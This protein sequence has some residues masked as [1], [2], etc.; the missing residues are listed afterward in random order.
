MLVPDIPGIECPGMLWP[1]IGMDELVAG[2][3]EACSLGGLHAASAMAAAVP[4][5]ATVA[6]DAIL[7][8]V[9]LLEN[10]MG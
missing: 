6:I 8:M 2:M 4:A 7:N 1:D 10:W 3:V 9:E 5:T